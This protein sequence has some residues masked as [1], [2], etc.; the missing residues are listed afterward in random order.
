MN[1]PFP[2]MQRK[3]DRSRPPC[4]VDYRENLLRTEESLMMSATAI[5]SSRNRLMEL[6]RNYTSNAFKPVI[7]EQK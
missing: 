2:I 1:I 4:P 3:C 7:T 6:H 5:D